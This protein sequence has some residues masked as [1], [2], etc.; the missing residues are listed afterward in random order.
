M[1]CTLHM[2]AKRTPSSEKL[3]CSRYIYRA[4]AMVLASLFIGYETLSAA[5]LFHEGQLGLGPTFKIADGFGPTEGRKGLP[6][7]WDNFHAWPLS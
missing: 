2:E 4:V 1:A 3:L 7:T 6:R 5:D